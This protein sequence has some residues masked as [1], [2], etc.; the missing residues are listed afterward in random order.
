VATEQLGDPTLL[1]AAR[2]D[3]VSES[4]EELVTVLDADERL[5]MV[6]RRLAEVSVRGVPDADAVS[7]VTL[8]NGAGERTAAASDDAVL[9]IE[10]A[11]FA[12][13]RGPCLAAAEAGRPI[14]VLVADV[15]EQWP[16]FAAAAERAGVQAYLTAPLVLDGDDP[17]LLGA[18]NVHGYV[19]TAF[20]PFDEALLRLFTTAASAAISTAR[21][22]QRFRELTG[23]LRSALV[24][25][26]AIDQAKGVLM[27]VH[28][29]D[30]DAAF[31][32]LVAESQRTNVKVHEVAVR[33][34]A[35]LRRDQT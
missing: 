19:D 6:L 5:E 12:A 13:G 7:V 2:L 20:D 9:Q 34:L 21:R 27:G 29:I 30:A 22:Y 35:S 1:A 8:F 10:D 23:Q 24:S 3:E 18:L 15:R 4:L 14:R 11:Q 31:D 26:A 28:G 33:L 25:R 16:E 17:L 32:R